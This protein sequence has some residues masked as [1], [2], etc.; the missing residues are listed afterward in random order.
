MKKAEARKKMC[1]RC[2]RYYRGTPAISRVDNQTQICPDCGTRESL[3]SLGVDKEER[4]TILAIIHGFS[5][6]N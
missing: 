6:E 2:S 3:E 4:E 1:P 5:K